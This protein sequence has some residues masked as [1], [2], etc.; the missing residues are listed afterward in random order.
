MFHKYLMGKAFPQD[1]RETF[2][3]A[4]LSFLIHT[5][6]PILFI[7]TLSTDVEECFREK[8]LA[9]NLKS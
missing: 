9:T 8:T 5:S 2:C 3:F 1:T 6:V 4:R 7:H